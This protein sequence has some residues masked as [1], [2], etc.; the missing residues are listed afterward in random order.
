MTEQRMLPVIVASTLGITIEWYDFFLY[1][2]VAALVF[3]KLFFPTF[4]PFVTTMLSLTTF[5]VG[6]IALSIGGL[7]FGRLVD[8]IGRKSTLIITLLKPFHSY[9]LNHLLEPFQ[10]HS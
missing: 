1:G 5:L 10:T 2:T 3:P 9:H 4:D 7:V 6:F 8:G